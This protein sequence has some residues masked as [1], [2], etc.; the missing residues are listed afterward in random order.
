MRGY[1][2]ILDGKIYRF[3]TKKAARLTAYW[4][5]G[6]TAAKKEAL[7]LSITKIPA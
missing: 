3:K 5:G 4:Y 2:F 6:N 1:Q 7:I